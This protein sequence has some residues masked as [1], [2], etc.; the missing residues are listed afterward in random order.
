MHCFNILFHHLNLV[1]KACRKIPSV[2]PTSYV[3]TIRFFHILKRPLYSGLHV[4]L[5]E[6]VFNCWYCGLGT[7]LQFLLYQWVNWSNFWIGLLLLQ[8]VWSSTSKDSL[9][10]WLIRLTQNLWVLALNAVN[11]YFCNDGSKLAS[12][13]SYYH[14]HNTPTIYMFIDVIHIMLYNIGFVAVTWS[15]V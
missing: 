14:I 12:W 8:L 11:K 1:W 15:S 3:F 2:I 9:G 13:L 6:I 5:Q 10:I 4:Y 7:L